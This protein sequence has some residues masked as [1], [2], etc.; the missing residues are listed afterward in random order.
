MRCVSLEPPYNARK[1]LAEKTII[2]DS[3]VYQRESGVWSEAKQQLFIDSI[4]NGYDVPKLYFHDLRDD[5]KSHYKF[6]V[7]DGKQRIH[8]IWRFLTNELPLGHDV[9]V[10]PEDKKLSEENAKAGQKWS[11]LNEYWQ[12]RI[13]DCV[14]PIIVIQN[15]SEYDIE[16][17]FSR[18][19]NGEPLS[20]AEKR[21]AMGGK[22]C[23][24]IRKI[25]LHKFFTECATFPTG[26]NQHYEAAAKFI[27]M[28]K[29]ASGS[30]NEIF[31]ILKKRFLDT[32]TMENK[33][34]SNVEEN[35][36]RHLVEGNLKAMIRIFDKKDP[37]LKRLSAPQIY[38]A[39]C[40]ETRA[41]YGHRELDKKIRSFLSDFQIRRSDNLRIPEE[42]DRD[43]VLLDFDRLMS[44][45]NDKESMRRRVEI[46]TRYFLENNPDVVMKDK[47]RA[48]THE[49]R[50]VIWVKDG[51]KCVK[52]GK[53]ISLD[54]MDADHYQPH[55]HGGK[56]TLENARALC[57]PCNRG[58][59][60]KVSPN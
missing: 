43:T 3:P 22:M 46:M 6:A 45:N 28:E 19:N 58:N 34:M 32:M 47:Q 16:E 48:Y 12:G 60:S 20:G 50:Y 21:N 49:E 44:Q 36:I 25:A 30:S 40:R 57:I 17:L 51:K 10:L 53:K 37:L 15:A 26:R 8:A 4:L 54:E 2:N 27:L 59:G 38:Y 35:N 1:L 7:V 39:F 5:N 14:L 24:L 33:N 56:T 9:D 31:C 29:T 11:D 42:D 52:C 41:R 13:G 23:K 18:L 55:A